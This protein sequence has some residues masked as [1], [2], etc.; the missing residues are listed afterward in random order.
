MGKTLSK[1]QQMAV[2]HFRGPCLCMA[3][4]GS[5]KTLVITERISSL[6]K[7]RGI[8]PRRIL[9]VTFTRDAAASMKKRCEDE[10]HIYPS[11]AFGTFHSIFYNILLKE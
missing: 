6:V 8:E 10:N 11:P 7:Y 4:P 5:G 2:S 9:V 1:E 3:G